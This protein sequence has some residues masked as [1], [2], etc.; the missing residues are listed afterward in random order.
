MQDKVSIIIPC[1]NASE[2]IKETLQSI[3]LQ[4]HR[5]YE[6]II[7]DD[8][9]S[10]TSKEIISEIKEHPLTYIFQ[11]NQGVSAARNKGL[12]HANGDYYLFL[13]AD[14]LLETDFLKQRIHT[15]QN[16]E[17]ALFACSKALLINNK[18]EA[19][20]IE[21]EPVCE[22]VELEICTYKSSYCSCPSNYLITKKFKEQ[23]IRFEEKLSNSADRFFLLHLNKLGKGKIVT[24]ASKLKYRIHSKSMSKTINPKNI[25]DLILFYQLI[26][27]SNLVPQVYY[28]K[29]K[30][31]T[32]RIT[33]S[34]ALLIKKI[35]LAFKAIFSVLL[36]F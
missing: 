20:G 35:P 28:I 36:K 11:E 8:G 4:S 33:F 5:N 21:Y 13:D 32:F 27:K 2:F 15:L 30:L 26:L 24:G 25:R 18:G 17:N 16:D 3:F 31:R 6:I 7:V 23:G 12:S 1:Y 19:L 9:S 29:L 22:D 10:D 14:D 34:E